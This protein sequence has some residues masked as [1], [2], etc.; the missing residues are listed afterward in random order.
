MKTLQLFT[1]LLFLTFATPAL[2]AGQLVTIGVN[3]MVCD[4]CA[5]ALEKVFNE[6]EEV[7]KIEVSLED[8]AVRVFLKE[9][10]NLDDDALREMVVNSGYNVRDITRTEYDGEG[11]DESAL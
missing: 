11:N 9:G 5:I 8:K 2:A 7:K 1:A 3:G 10:Q 4:F 6:K